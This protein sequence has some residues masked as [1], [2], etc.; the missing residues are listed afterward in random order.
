[1]WQIVWFLKTLAIYRLSTT[2][3]KK[4]RT[5]LLMHKNQKSYDIEESRCLIQLRNC[6]RTRLVTCHDFTHRCIA[7]KSDSRFFDRAWCITT[8][9][10]FFFFFFLSEVVCST[11]FRDAIFFL[12]QE[13]SSWWFIMKI[14]DRNHVTSTVFFSK[15][16]IWKAN[17]KIFT[18]E[19]ITFLLRCNSLYFTSG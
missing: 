7:A 13:H 2:L 14:A 16:N 11:P 9:V 8:M 19:W 5:M 15:L 17:W 12:F 3:D 18:Q 1:M 10:L 4:K 6:E